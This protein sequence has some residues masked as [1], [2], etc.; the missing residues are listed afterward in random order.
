MQA[1]LR[2]VGGS[3]CDTD[4]STPTRL[5]YASSCFCEHLRPDHELC[6]G[7]GLRILPTRKA[8]EGSPSLE[9]HVLRTGRLANAERCAFSCTYQTARRIRSC[10]A[11]TTHRM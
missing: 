6:S 10:S 9:M 2:A 3:G 1:S 5:Q 7:L 8:A 4:T 11:S